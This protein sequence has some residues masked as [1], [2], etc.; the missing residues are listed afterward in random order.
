MTRTIL[1]RHAL[2]HVTMDPERRE[3]ADGGLFIRDGWI[4]QVGPT[5][6]LPETADEVVDLSGHVVLPGLV[7]THHLF[8]T[9]TRVVPAAQDVNLFEWLVALYPIWARLSTDAIRVSTLVG[10][11]KLALSGCTTARWEGRTIG[12]VMAE[13]GRDAVD[14][15]CDLLL[16]EDLRVNEVTPGPWSETLPYF[17]HHPAG[18]VGTDSTFVG[19]KL[20]PRTYGS[21]P[22]ILGQHVRDEALL[23]L[24]DAIRKMTGAAAA[25]LGLTDRGVIRDGAAADVVVLDPATIRNNATYEEPRQFPDG[26]DHV[27]VNGRLVV[28]LG[29]HTGALPGRALR[30]ARGGAG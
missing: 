1:V 5:A 9:L 6:A 29:E 13:T 12:D 23:G 20:S 14:T 10:L 8:Q 19:A 4:E 16:E 21:F 27:I 11:A 25:R 22:R 3:I 18:M 2:M 7:N 26:I 24:E 17:I 15:L 30:H 28:D